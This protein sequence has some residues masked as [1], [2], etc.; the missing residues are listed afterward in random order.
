MKRVFQLAHDDVVEDV[1]RFVVS[2]MKMGFEDSAEAR[3]IA[4]DQKVDWLQLQT[5]LMLVSPLG[6]DVG[7]LNC[8]VLDFVTCIS[9]QAGRT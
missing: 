6:V 7:E 1:R 3:S 8:A 4:K 2:Q 5:A 9:E